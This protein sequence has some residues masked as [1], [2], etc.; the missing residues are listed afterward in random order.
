MDE[1]TR[2]TLFNIMSNIKDNILWIFHFLLSYSFKNEKK[3]SKKIC[4]FKNVKYSQGQF[5]NNFR[6]IFHQIVYEGGISTYSIS[7]KHIVMA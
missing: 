1:K 2:Q 5:N 4:F 7:F 3:L 6:I